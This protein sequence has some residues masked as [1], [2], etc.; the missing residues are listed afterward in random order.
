MAWTESQMSAHYDT[1][2][3]VWNFFKSKGLSDIA[4]AA[5][6][7]N[8]E[9]ES[10]F[11]PSITEDEGSGIGLV[12]W[13]YKTRKQGLY[14][15]AKENEKDWTDLYVQLDYIWKELNTSEYSS[16]LKYLKCS[17]KIDDAVVLFENGYEK[18]SVKAMDERKE[19]AKYWHKQ[20]KNESL[21]NNKEIHTD[22]KRDSAGTAPNTQENTKHSA[23]KSAN[24]GKQQHDQNKPLGCLLAMPVVIL[25]IFIC[26]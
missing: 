13:T 20:F 19:Y 25:L 17:T 7:G 10:H 26:W 4:C 11:D 5:I 21:K 8:I 1:A 15:F 6:M 9:R 24:K 18:A 12:Q 3:T 22:N 23:D 16:T 14:D 2:K